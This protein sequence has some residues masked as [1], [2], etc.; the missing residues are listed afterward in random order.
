MARN[1][2]LLYVIMAVSNI[3][4][5]W[6]AQ[7]PWGI[8]SLCKVWNGYSYLLKNCWNVENDPPPPPKKKKKKKRKKKKKQDQAKQAKPSWRPEKMCPGYESYCMRYWAGW[9]KVDMYTLP[10][11]RK[12]MCLCTFHLSEGVAGVMKQWVVQVGMAGR[13]S[14]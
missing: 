11:I 13:K 3:G 1:K 2:P 14:K 9:V 4:C 7:C 6:F 5:C 8:L 10:E 12:C